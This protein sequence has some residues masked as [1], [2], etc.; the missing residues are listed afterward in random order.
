MVSC[1]LNYK[2]YLTS[3]NFSFQNKT[4]K[5]KRNIL[6]LFFILNHYSVCDFPSTQ[7]SYY[8]YQ[9][10]RYR[11]MHK[12][13]AYLNFRVISF[14]KERKVNCTSRSI[15]ETVFLSAFQYNYTSPIKI[16]IQRKSLIHLSKVKICTEE[17]TNKSHL[18]IVNISI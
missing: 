17:I 6:K 13:V 3:C 16:K 5:T 15:Q 10:S 9:R 4:L 1:P 7:V 2:N 18:K 12:T 14:H 8:K 11:T